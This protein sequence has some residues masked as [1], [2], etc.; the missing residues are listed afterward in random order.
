MTN[1][2]DG[3]FGTKVTKVG[4][5]GKNVTSDGYICDSKHEVWVYTTDIGNDGGLTPGADNIIVSFVGTDT[6]GLGCVGAVLDGSLKFITDPDEWQDT[7]TEGLVTLQQ[8]VANCSGFG[9]CASAGG[10]FYVYSVGY[11]VTSAVSNVVVEPVIWVA[12]GAKSLAK[13]T[14]GK[15]NPFCAEEGQHMAETNYS[16]VGNQMNAVLK[17][18][19]RTG[20]GTT[21]GEGC[22]DDFGGTVFHNANGRGHK[23]AI[24]ITCD[25]V[26]MYDTELAGTADRT[27]S[28]SN[29]RFDPTMKQFK[30]TKPGMWVVTVKSLAAHAECGTPTLNKT[31]NI[32]VP[33]P[34]DWDESAPVIETQTEQVKEVTKTLEQIGIKDVDPLKAF[35]GVVIGGGL[36]VYGVLS[37]LTSKK[38]EDISKS[39]TE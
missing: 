16:P 18:E 9:D 23:V 34:A 10:Q 37:L 29:I 6:A 5:A 24:K 31:W 20:T 7:V 25:G 19:F 39:P 38:Q 27:T 26:S 35:A 28:G 30:I 22:F 2:D 12:S 11:G 15:Y 4:G 3:I 36:L 8:N 21:S 33:K 32:F 1:L 13:K 17:R 14:C